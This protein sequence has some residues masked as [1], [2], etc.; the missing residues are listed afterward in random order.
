MPPKRNESSHGD[1]VREF[2]IPLSAFPFEAAHFVDSAYGCLAGLG[3]AYGRL[4]GLGWSW[5]WLPTGAQ[6]VTL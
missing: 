1:L 3:T 6:L 4:A 2:H 5:S